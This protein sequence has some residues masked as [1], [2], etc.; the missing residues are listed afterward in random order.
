MKRV[1]RIKMPYY[2]IR[3]GK[4]PGIYESWNEAKIHVEGCKD[5]VHKKYVD[6]M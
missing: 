3:R 1:R 6:Y 2:A 5:A 4:V